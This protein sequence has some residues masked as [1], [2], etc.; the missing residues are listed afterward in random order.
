MFILD[1]VG[2]KTTFLWSTLDDIELTYHDV[3]VFAKPE[4]KG[5][6]VLEKKTIFVIILL[7]INTNTNH[8]PLI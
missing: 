7:Y 2:E 5:L 8:K 6:E 3:T 1:L 4:F